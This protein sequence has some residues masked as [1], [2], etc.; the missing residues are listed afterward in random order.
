MFEEKKMTVANFNVVFA[1]EELESPM[2]DYFED[3]LMPAMSANIIQKKG[4]NEFLFHDVRVKKESKGS[5]VLLGNIVKKTMLEIKSDLDNEGNLIEKD[6]H[7]SSAP[8]SMFVIYLTNHRMVLVE[9]KK[10]SPTIAS[11]RSLVKYVLNTYIK[12]ANKNTEEEKLPK[13][14]V[15]IVGIPR[16]ENIETILKEAKKVTSLTLRF[17]PLNGDGDINLSGSFALLSKES[18]QM[19]GAKTGGITYNSPKN[20]DGIL[21]IIDEAN[22]TVEPVLYVSYDGKSRTRVKESEISENKIIKINGDC[23]ENEG[24][25]I[26]EGRK[27]KS[28]NY[29]SQENSQIYDRNKSKILKFF[30]E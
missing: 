15:N 24:Y 1:N 28:I 2:L 4:D 23:G 14:L 10:G 21:Q 20:I 26:E 18:R 12:M 9:N 11:F 25:I 16:I 7:Y 17:Y 27:I 5:Y 6:E 19:V 8:Y 22:A 3:I 13:A 29:Q 30:K